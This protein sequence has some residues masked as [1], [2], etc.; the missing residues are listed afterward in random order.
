[1]KDVLRRR[2]PDF[3]R[4]L[5][6]ESGSRYVFDNLLPGL[7]EVH[8]PELRVD[9]VTCYTGEPAGLR[10]GG[11][12]YR[13]WD[14]PGSDGRR[15]LLGELKSNHYNV[16]G[17]ICSG[18]PIMT[19]WKWWL[20]AQIPAKL[21]ILNENG[22]YFWFDYTNWRLMLHFMLFRAGLSGGDA[23]TTITRLLMFPFMVCYLLLF[24]AAVHLRRKVR[25]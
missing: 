16:C 2:I 6:I 12:V 17:I 18:E 15:R 7:Y 24:A 5:L 22:D 19:K 3:R 20:S 10:S 13:V 8:G 23:V 9:L 14:Y 21:F 25:T 1:M 4:V 11:Q